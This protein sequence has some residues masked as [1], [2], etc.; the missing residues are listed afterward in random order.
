MEFQEFYRRWEERY[1]PLI[2]DTLKRFVDETEPWKILVDERISR[3]RADYTKF[4]ELMIGNGSKGFVEKKIE[5][6]LDA[7]TES[8]KAMIQA[9]VRE[10]F[11]KRDA[12]ANQI[13]EKRKDR[14]WSIALILISQIVG[15]V[16]LFFKDQL[17]TK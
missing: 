11:A 3:M 10:E 8:V 5:E 15:F 4:R 6:K 1:H 9:A 17:I 13:L 2:S 7:F 16:V 14:T 12:I